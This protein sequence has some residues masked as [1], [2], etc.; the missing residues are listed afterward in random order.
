[1]SKKSFLLS[2]IVFLCLVPAPAASHQGAP[3]E[4]R[5]GEFVKLAIG[6]DDL[7]VTMAAYA[8]LGFTPLPIFSPRSDSALTLTDGQLAIGL[9]TLSVMGPVLVFR[10]ESILSVKQFLDSLGFTV[11]SDVMGPSIRE[12]RITSPSG[13]L[14]AI[15][16]ATVEQSISYPPGINL[17]CGKHTELSLATSDL[18][19]ER[20][21]WKDLGFSVKRDSTAPYNFAI[22]T[23]GKVNIG[24]HESKDIDRIAITYFAPDM[25]ARLER[26]RAAGFEFEEV[27]P[28]A[29]GRSAN[30]ILKM[31]GNQSI[32]LFEG[33]Q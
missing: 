16:N 9:E 19:R 18:S 13:I 5:I 22:Y 10:T 32:F 17:M 33:N 21:F 14:I 6:V 3:P 15:R 2:F 1:M 7:W 25:E 24:I 4:S 30:A 26:L 31:P 20:A 27:I 23:D 11:F 28:S 12:L 29:D 8:R